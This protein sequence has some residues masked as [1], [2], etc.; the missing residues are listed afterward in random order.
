MIITIKTAG[1][2]FKAYCFARA[3]KSRPP[4]A[5]W[6]RCWPDP[7]VFIREGGLFQA[8]ECRLLGGVPARPGRLAV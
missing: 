2:I 1:Q 3:A 4:P 8:W 7:P 6:E 5:L